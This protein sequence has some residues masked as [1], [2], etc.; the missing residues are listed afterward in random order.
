MVDIIPTIQIV[1]KFTH[2]GGWFKVNMYISFL[3]YK[4]KQY[5]YGS[6]KGR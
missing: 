6:G 3:L 2:T 5:E 4:T 1:E